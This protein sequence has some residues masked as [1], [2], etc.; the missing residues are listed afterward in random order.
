MV[1]CITCFD[2]MNRLGVDRQ[3]DRQ[4]DEHTDRQNYDSNRGHLP[5]CTM[6]IKTTC[7]SYNEIKITNTKVD[8]KINFF[9]IINYPFYEWPEVASTNNKHLKVGCKL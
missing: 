8:S 1:W 9:N 4:T 6:K 5:T 3:C 2:I 7:T